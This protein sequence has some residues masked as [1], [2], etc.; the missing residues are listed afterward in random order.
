MSDIGKEIRETMEESERFL[1]ETSKALNYKREAFKNL[2]KGP[3]E[4]EF[5]KAQEFVA[6]LIR[7]YEKEASN[8]IHLPW[9]REEYQRKANYLK[10]VNEYAW[11]Y[12]DLER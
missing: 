3:A 12:E 6:S 11:R 5:E 1:K 9:A 4:D 8:D 2:A 7:T 10:L